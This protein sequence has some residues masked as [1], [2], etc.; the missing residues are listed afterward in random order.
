LDRN[1]FSRATIPKPF[2]VANWV[3]AARAFYA[4]S[5]VGYALAALVSGAAPS[6]ALRWF[7]VALALGAL[8]LDGVDGRLARQLGQTS[9]FG[10]R[11]DMETDAVMVLGLSLLAWLCGQVGAW[12]LAGGLM[13]YIF[14]L[15]GWAWPALAAPLPRRLRRQAACVA[16]MAVLILAAAPAIAPTVA[17]PLCFAAL[18]GL[19]YSF[20]VD[21][22]SLLASRGEEKKEAVI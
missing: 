12:V 20:A 6:A 19:S 14:V 10:A 7:W 13:R 16:Q 15:G 3:T 4:V 2:G 11:F 17:A 1:K 21:V 5:L 9:A 22:A 8:A 18:A